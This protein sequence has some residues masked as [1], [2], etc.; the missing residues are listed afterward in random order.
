MPSDPPLKLGKRDPSRLTAHEDYSG[1]GTELEGAVR[2]EHRCR[3]SAKRSCIIR[4]VCRLL[5]LTKGLAGSSGSCT[6][7][8]TRRAVSR[9]GRL[10]QQAA[11]ATTESRYRRL[12]YAQPA[13]RA[14]SLRKTPEPCAV[15]ALA[16]SP[17]VGLSAAAR[18]IRPSMIG[19][20]LRTLRRSRSDC[21]GKLGIISAPRRPSAQ[22]FR[23]VERVAVV[24]SRILLTVTLQACG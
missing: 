5:C 12:H 21:P 6:L 16:P 9:D 20:R 23:I 3:S 24:G 2:P 18:P 10:R 13:P 19:L 7:S 8:S 15:P 17:R 11:S 14:A 22:L 1:P 4:Y